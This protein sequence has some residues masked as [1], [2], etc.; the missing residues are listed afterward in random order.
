MSKQQVVNFARRAVGGKIAFTGKRGDVPKGC[1]TF[2]GEKAFVLEGNR[3]VIAA[4]KKEG[5]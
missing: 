4:V 1:C 3:I 5:T 2:G